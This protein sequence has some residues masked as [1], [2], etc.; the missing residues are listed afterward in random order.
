M[1][2]CKWNIFTKK[3]TL[4]TKLRQIKILREKKFD[5][6]GFLKLRRNSIRMSMK[7]AFHELVGQYYEKLEWL[8]L[9]K[10]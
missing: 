6:E 7:T 3:S 2:I 8:I 5:V 1:F 10:N 9:F 4:E